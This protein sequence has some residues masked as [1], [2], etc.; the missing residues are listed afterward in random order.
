MEP[1]AEPV[2]NGFESAWQQRFT[3]SSLH[4]DDGGDCPQST[5]LSPE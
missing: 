5:T 3:V 1:L 2:L 4:N